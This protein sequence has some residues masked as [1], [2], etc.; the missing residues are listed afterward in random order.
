MYIRVVVAVAVAIVVALAVVLLTRVVQ[1]TLFGYAYFDNNGTTIPHPQVYLR[2]IYGA[3]LGNPSGHY[4]NR[5]KQYFAEAESAILQLISTG[6]KPDGKFK[7][8][9][10]S[11]A[12]EGNNTVIRG[13]G[14]YMR[15][16][17]SKPHFILSSLEHHTSIECAKYLERTGVIT[18]TLARPNSEG[19]FD[20]VAFATLI[21]PTTALVSIMH[22]NNELGSENPIEQIAETIK[23]IRP[24][25][26]IHVDCVQSFGKR[27]LPISTWNVDAV[28][29]SLH[30]LDGPQ[31]LGA[32]II[33]HEFAKRLVPLV[34]GTQNGGLRGGTEN[35]AAISAVPTTIRITFTDRDRKT[36]RILAMKH[37]IVNAITEAFAVDN[38][39]NY[40][41]QPDSYAPVFRSDGSKNNVK[42]VFLG[43][44]KPGTCLP[45]DDRVS[46][47]TIS[48]SIVKDS[49]Q[50]H[51]C[52]IKLRKYLL[53]RR[54]VVS[55]GSACATEASY[56]NHV[57]E[58]I[59][60]PFIIRCGVVR[61]S[62]GDY[63]S[64][65]QVRRLI[66][67]LINGIRV[68]LNDF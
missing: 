8:I 23:A 16:A 55:T 1:D 53:D 22:V 45:D 35:T 13:F 56:L 49:L 44:T 41:G 39:A 61:I 7:V 31:G 52:N 64:G 43:P 63:T 65:F 68:Q 9:W 29:I 42:I 36:A 24:D 17:G 3:Y 15:E 11:G 54:I 5:A 58:G 51:F 34:F 25:I 33:T 21:Q 20:P 67:H 12:S 60:A 46:P 32:L 2:M 50:N 66:K 4:A 40:Y 48:M 14:E 27:I 59:M 62:L 19:V 47:A 18:L 26:Y 57:L 37:Q 6:G 30:K 38:Y 10:N 28:T